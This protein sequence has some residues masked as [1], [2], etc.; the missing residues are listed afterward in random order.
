MLN[1][2]R[3][4]LPFSF[5]WDLHNIIFLPKFCFSSI[6]CIMMP[7]TIVNARC[8]EEKKTLPPFWIYIF[9]C[10]TQRGISHLLISSYPGAQ[11][12]KEV[13]HCFPPVGICTSC[14]PSSKA[15]NGFAAHGCLLNSQHLSLISLHLAYVTLEQYEILSVTKLRTVTKLNKMVLMFNMDEF[16]HRYFVVPGIHG[17]M[18]AQ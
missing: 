13:A 5:C 9:S 17:K 1:N 12:V 10:W 15:H 18:N 11:G 14:W 3:M 2:N 8:L 4:L 7:L 6:D 16:L